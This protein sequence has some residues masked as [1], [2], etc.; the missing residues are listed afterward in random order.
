MI[1]TGVDIVKIDRI[2]SLY[3][4]KKIGEYLFSDYELAYIEKK[5]TIDKATNQKLIAYDTVA[6]L[7]ACKEAVTKALGIGLSKKLNFKEVEI[8]HD[9]N[10]APIVKLSGYIKDYFNSLGAKDCSISISHDAGVAIAIC[11]II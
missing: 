2:K 4:K 7:Y 3:Q 6:G 10:G 11:T 5:S 9:S 1:K 8:N